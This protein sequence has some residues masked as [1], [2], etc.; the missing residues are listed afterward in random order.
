MEQTLNQVLENIPQKT[1]RIGQASA[2]RMVRQYSIEFAKRKEMAQDAIKRLRD[3]LMASGY[4]NPTTG[5][6]EALAVDL[7]L[8]VKVPGPYGGLATPKPTQ[9]PD[10]AL[11]QAINSLSPAN[12][13]LLTNVIKQLTS[14]AIQ[15]L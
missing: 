3:T 4:R 10:S 6:L 5:P 8:V 1:T 13:A 15:A 11:V 12:K 7:G 2:S 14:T 9:E